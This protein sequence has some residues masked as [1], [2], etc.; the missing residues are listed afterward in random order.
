MWQIIIGLE[1]QN[2]PVRMRAVVAVVNRKVTLLVSV[3]TDDKMLRSAAESFFLAVHLK[4]Q[5]GVS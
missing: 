4:L 2:D 3:I 1:H 5:P